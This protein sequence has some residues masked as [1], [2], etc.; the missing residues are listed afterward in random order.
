VLYLLGY[1]SEALMLWDAA[2]S[3]YQRV[4]AV[5][6]RFRDAAQRLATLEQAPE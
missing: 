6:I 2:V 3:Y 1:A 4:F 5:D